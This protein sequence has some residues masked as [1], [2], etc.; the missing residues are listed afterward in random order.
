MPPDLFVLTELEWELE[1]AGG[2]NLQVA[3]RWHQLLK[4]KISSLRGVLR[5][6]DQCRAVRHETDR[7]GPD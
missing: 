5:P 1:A 4:T 2:V 3:A 6:T 7:S